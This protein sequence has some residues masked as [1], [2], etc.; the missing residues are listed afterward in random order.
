M[1]AF[2]VWDRR[3]RSL[4]LARDPM[5]MKPLYYWRQ[6]T[7]AFRVR[8]GNQGVSHACRTS[9]PRSTR[10][11]VRQFLELNFITDEHESSLAGVLNCP[12][13]TRLRFRRAM[14]KPVGRLC[15]NAIFT[16]PPVEPFAEANARSTQRADRLYAVLEPVVQQ[17]L[18]A[19]VPV[20]LLLS[21]GLDSSIHRGPGG[22][23]YATL[24]TISMAFADSQ[25]DER[26]FARLVSQHIGTEHE[27][28]LIQPREV[29]ADLERSVWYL[30][31]PVRRLGSA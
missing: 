26:P 29:A 31:R 30:R 22:P 14:C 21:G 3:E 13:A 20:G 27:E 6:P 15:R 25:I 9:G 19:D 16:P 11:R 4:F 12:P 5:G 7:G 23:A 28:I 18:I 8:L 10:A 24:R 17:H 2:A 1:F